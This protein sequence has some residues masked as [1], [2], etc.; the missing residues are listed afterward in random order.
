MLYAMY[1]THTGQRAIIE[2]MQTNLSIVCERQGIMASELE[3]FSEAICLGDQRR[4]R[5]KPLTD[6]LSRLSNHLAWRGAT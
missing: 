6:L 1:G 2:N 3:A 5:L 4:R